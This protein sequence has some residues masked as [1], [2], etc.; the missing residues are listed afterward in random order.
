V[1][2]AQLNKCS[3]PV[4][5][6]FTS[7]EAGLRSVTSPA[8]YVEPASPPDNNHSNT[9]LRNELQEMQVGTESSQLVDEQQNKS[10]GT[11]EKG[12]LTDAISTEHRGTIT[13]SGWVDGLSP[14]T[15]DSAPELEDVEE[16]TTVVSPIGRS[17]KKKRTEEWQ[18]TL[19]RIKFPE[20]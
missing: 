7:L 6:G 8:E 1:N 17:K 2:L 20:C 12:Q 3:G 10:R 19:S 18:H 14:D 13:R 9:S 11:S 5:F 4:S 16:L 15:K